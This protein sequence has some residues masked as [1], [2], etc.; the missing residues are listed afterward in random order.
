MIP[1]KASSSSSSSL[2]PSLPSAHLHLMRSRDSLSCQPALSFGGSGRNEVNDAFII[3][4][5]KNISKRGEKMR[6]FPGEGG[7]LAKNLNEKTHGRKPK[8][9]FSVN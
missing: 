5:R 3:K 2:F 1:L 7:S 8:L 6:S 9:L 4:F